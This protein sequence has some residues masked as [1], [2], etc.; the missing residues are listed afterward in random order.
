MSK[1]SKQ[2]TFNTT[3]VQAQRSKDR[4]CALVLCLLF[5][6]GSKPK[7]QILDCT[8]VLATHALHGL[9]DFAQSQCPCRNFFSPAR[10]T[11]V[12][13][14]VQLLFAQYI[15]KKLRF[16]DLAVAILIGC[17]SWG[18]VLPRTAR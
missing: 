11:E 14:L 7:L 3:R 1:L 17:D 12:A 13:M 10:N 6:L 9:R 18:L 16:T 8:L 15:R 5:C 4:G 2:E